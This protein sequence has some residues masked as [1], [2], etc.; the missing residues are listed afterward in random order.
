MLT[1]DNSFIEGFFPKEVIE[2][3]ELVFNNYIINKNYSTG[4]YEK[5]L[6]G[7]N[8]DRFK[9][10]LTYFGIILLGI[11]SFS[12]TFLYIMPMDNM[13]FTLQIYGSLS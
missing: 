7:M 12:L 3:I 10:G 13:Q 6:T 11:I 8:P 5:W 2:N 1:K 4:L 9:R